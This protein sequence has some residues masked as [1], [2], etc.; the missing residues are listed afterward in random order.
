ML[1]PIA[2]QVK[3]TQTYYPFEIKVV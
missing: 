1:K 2:F 3:L